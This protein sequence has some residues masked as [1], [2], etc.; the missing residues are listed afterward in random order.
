MEL[1]DSLIEFQIDTGTETTIIPEQVHE[2][3][4]HFHL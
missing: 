4:P 2:I 3:A 1:N